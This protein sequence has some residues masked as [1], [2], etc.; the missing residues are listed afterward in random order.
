[1]SGGY[2]GDQRF[3]VSTFAYI[4]KIVFYCHATASKR[5]AITIILDATERSINTLAKIIVHRP[6]IDI[7]VYVTS[8]IMFTIR[9]CQRYT[10]AVNYQWSSF[11]TSREKHR[12]GV[13]RV[14]GF[15]ITVVQA[16]FQAGAQ[17][18]ENIVG[19]LPPF[20]FSYLSD[21]CCNAF[22]AGMVGRK[23]KCGAIPGDI[24]H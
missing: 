11:F 16:D 10:A 1:M 24:S 8:C 6:Y 15:F 14:F 20:F 5:I 19:F 9:C 7:G 3:D 21:S 18:H 12:S 13:A 23:Y 22:Y 2:G 4:V 17:G